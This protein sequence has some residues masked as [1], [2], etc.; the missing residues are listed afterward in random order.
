MVPPSGQLMLVSSIKAFLAN[1]AIVRGRTFDSL[2][3]GAGVWGV[4]R[5]IYLQKCGGKFIYL[6]CLFESK[7]E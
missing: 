5:S 3:R 2:I 1:V 4:G 6:F 7:K